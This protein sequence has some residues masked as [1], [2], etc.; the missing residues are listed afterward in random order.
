M[1]LEGTV[2]MVKQYRWIRHDNGQWEPAS[3]HNKS[4]MILKGEMVIVSRIGWLMTYEG[5]V[6]IQGDITVFRDE[7]GVIWELGGV[8]NQV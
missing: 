6:E 1:S 4:G 5:R 3:I 2:Q 7:D 8:C